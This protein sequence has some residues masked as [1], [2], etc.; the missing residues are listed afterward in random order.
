MNTNVKTCNKSELCTHKTEQSLD[1]WVYSGL[2][3]NQIFKKFDN[4][5]E[6]VSVA[7]KYKDAHILYNGIDIQY[8]VMAKNILYYICTNTNEVII[9]GKAQE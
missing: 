5:L 1:V 9:L 7:I 8:G 3:E 4:M 2:C 6:A